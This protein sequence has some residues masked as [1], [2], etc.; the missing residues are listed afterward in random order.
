MDAA[1]HHDAAFADGPERRRHQR[2]DRRED[3]G[4]VERLGR[5]LVGAAGPRRA[6]ARARSPAPCVARPGEGEDLAALMPRHLRHDMRRR[7]EAVNAEALAGS[8][9]SFSER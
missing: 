6:Q 4:R 9:A 1:A 7:A 2:A 5:R 3:D 8:P